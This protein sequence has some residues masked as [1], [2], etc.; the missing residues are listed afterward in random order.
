LPKL[1]IGV[2]AKYM[3]HEDTYRSVFEAIKAAAWKN[4]TQASIVWL[5]AEELEKASEKKV[6]NILN[7]VDGVLVPGGFGIR[8]LEG[9]I[10]AAGYC[11][12]HKVPYLGLC[13]GL[14]MAVI[15][16]ARLGGERHANTVEISPQGECL[17]IDTMADQHG[18]QNT[19]GSM[20][21]GD[22]PCDIAKDSIA[23]KVYGTS[24]VDERHRHRCECSNQYRDSYE[25]WGI[26]AVGTSPD[27]KLVE[28]IEAT[29]HPYF[30]ASQFHPEFKS[31]PGK[32]HPLF[33]GFIDAV[34][35]NLQTLR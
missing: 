33:D 31:R 15:A 18:K 5:N 19:G 2:V 25:K 32:P 26:R 1:S 22:Y 35:N 11:L 23:H 17:V 9:K 3:D 12:E 10:R 13:L 8:G 28:I 34:K 7:T 27:G 30:L 24:K 4:K 16:A 20:R 6:K 14:Q 21:L 29:D